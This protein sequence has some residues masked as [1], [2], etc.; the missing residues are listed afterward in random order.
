M[1]KA[2][3][4]VLLGFFVAVIV[5]LCGAALIMGGFYIGKHEG[6]TFH[7]LQIVLRI[8][9]G[10]VPHLD[11]MTPIGVM[12]FAPI[13]LFVK[14]GYGI[15]M[16][17]LLSQTLMAVAFLPAV[18]WVAYSRMRGVLPYLF[19]LVIFV[20]LTALVHGESQPSVSISMHYN[21]WAWAAAFIAICT[22][23]IPAKEPVRPMVDGVII[24]LA[25]AFLLLTKVTY[26]AAFAIPVLV[27]IIANKSSRAIPA[28]L[29]SGLAAMAVVTL[30][31]GTGFWLAYLGDLLT[32]AGS[33]TRSHPGESF[34]AVVGAPAY[35][36]ASLVLIA[37]VVLLRQAGQA[38]GGLILLLLTPGFFFVT[39][40][41]FGND[42][43]WLLLLGVLLLAFLP[44][45]GIRNGFGWDMRNAVK[46]CALAAFSMTA[47]SF[48]N[49]A[50]SPFRHL[51]TEVEDY[52]ELL[53]KS[54]K[55]SDIFT[56][57]IRAIRADRQ[58]LMPLEGSGLEEYAELLEEKT[59]PTVF[60][61]ET[62]PQCE[63]MLG[64]TAWF[65]VIVTDLE[66]A[67]LADGKSI[68]AADLFS[69]HWLFGSLEPLKGG[70]PWYYGGLPGLADADYLLVPLCPI[71]PKLRD[72]I[73]TEVKEQGLE[74]D[75][76]RRTPLYIL[77]EPA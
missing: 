74:F 41:N 1:N 77:F 28:V 60:K 70:S 52:T 71:L 51:N 34:G 14:L 2:N 68:F 12:A 49:M 19:G 42:P 73:L 29:V 46:I 56:V 57:S 54:Q 4:T 43:Q 5:A 3:P 20:L 7:L 75:E 38:N 21:R 36:G 55:H 31:M 61:G 6:D 76:I 27:A 53:P 69:S 35:I 58:M 15:G 9:D 40:Q 62:L 18:W 10:Q 45:A 16:S 26:F 67:G 30:L 48:L 47:P 23:V 39:Y 13:A 65:D 11:F 8:A 72:Q 24:G 64:L 22:A 25:M 63:L 33:E 59:E 66:Q 32:V 37:G 50:Y 44:E 17:I